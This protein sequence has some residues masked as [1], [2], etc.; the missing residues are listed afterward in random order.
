MGEIVTERAALT[1]GGK[2]TARDIMRTR[3]M[4]LDLPDITSTQVRGDDGWSC[5][6]KVKARLKHEALET[7]FSAAGEG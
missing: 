5:Y 4:S 6:F 1:L 7:Q 3:M 2:T